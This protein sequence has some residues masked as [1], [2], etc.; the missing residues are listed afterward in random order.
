MTQSAEPPVQLSLRGVT[1]R[2]EGSGGTVT[3]QEGLRAAHQV[4][5]VVDDLRVELLQCGQRQL[6]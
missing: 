2:Y 1:K 6:R 3:G 5:V 4:K